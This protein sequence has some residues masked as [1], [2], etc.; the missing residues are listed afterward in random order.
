MTKTCFKCERTLPLTEFYRHPMMG[1][2][3]LG[4]CKACTKV[5]VQENYRRNVEYYRAY[6]KERTQ[7]PER[8]A[9]K[10]RYAATYLRLHPER[11]RAHGRVKYEIER[12]RMVRKPCEM[13]GSPETE[14]H[15]P[16][17]SKPLEVAWL[18][19]RHHR[20]VH[21]RLVK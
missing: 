18:C 8:R 20:E 15:H 4:K 11:L 3:H 1:D 5:D 13:C 19:L 17:Y 2:G 12:G 14:A 9:N 16:D 6:D 7:R 21:G 10:S